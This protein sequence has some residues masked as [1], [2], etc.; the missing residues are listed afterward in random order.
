MDDMLA[1]AEQQGKTALAI[2]DVTEL[3]EPSASWLSSSPT[4]SIK[5]PPPAI[6]LLLDLPFEGTPSMGHPFFESLA[7][8]LQKKG[9][10][11]LAGHLAIVMARES[12]SIPQR[13][14][15]GAKKAL[16]GVMTTCLN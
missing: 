7:G 6:P 14:R 1:P 9:T 2:V 11:P 10:A 4:H 5:T 3:E 12:G 8:P 16:H 13:W 15:I